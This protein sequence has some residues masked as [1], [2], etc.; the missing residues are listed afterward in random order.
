[1][2][3]QITFEEIETIQELYKAKVIDGCEVMLIMT[4]ARYAWRKG[5]KS[6]GRNPCMK[7]LPA[8]GRMLGRSESTMKRAVR[9]LEKE[10]VLRQIYMTRKKGKD[11]MGTTSHKKALSRISKGAKQ[12]PSHFELIL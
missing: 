4:V 1:M 3:V 10:N 2:F 12:L 7:S 5:H 6:K 9:R 11:M 8:M